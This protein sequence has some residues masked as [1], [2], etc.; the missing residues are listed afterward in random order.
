[1]QTTL[2]VRVHVLTAVLQNSV[3]VI[4]QWSPKVNKRNLRRILAAIFRGRGYCW[5]LT[6]SVEALIHNWCSLDLCYNPQLMSYSESRLRK[7][8]FFLL[9]MDKTRTA[10]SSSA[11]CK[12]FF[13]ALGKQEMI[14]MLFISLQNWFTV[15]VCAE[16][17]RNCHLEL[18]CSR[19]VLLCSDGSCGWSQQSVQTTD[20]RRRERRTSR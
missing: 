20:H 16:T 15:F 1:M 13:V 8:K 11:V 3:Y 9:W 18:L 4:S 6:N 12:S 7:Q 19:A 10:N 17:Q 14:T 5:L 2:Y